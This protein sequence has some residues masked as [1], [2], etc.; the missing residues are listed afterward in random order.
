MP[1]RARNVLLFAACTALT[2][3]AVASYYG[4]STS[5]VASDDGWRN[6]VSWRL[7]LLAR[8]A[9]GQVPDLS[10]PELWEMANTRGGF[11][12]E[13]FVRN[14]VSLDGSLLSPHTTDEDVA[15]GSRVFA[16]HCAECHGRPGPGRK[17]PALDQPGYSRGDSDLAIYK[18]LRNGIPA[19]GMA[20]PAI[21][22]LERWQ[23][24]AYLRDL[25]T[26][27]TRRRQGSTPHVNVAARQLEMTAGTADEWPTHSGSVDGQRYSTLAEVTP[28][29]VSQLRLLWSRQFSGAGIESTPLVAD[30]MMYITLPPSTVMALDVDSGVIVWTYS[31]SLPSDLSLC[32][33]QV[34]RGAAILGDSLFLGTLDGHLV[35]LNANTGELLW[36]TMVA[37]P[38][39]GYTITGAPLVSGRSVVIGTAGAE[40]GIRGILDAYDPATGERQWRF[41]TIPGPDETGHETWENEAWRTGGGST[42]VTGSYDPSLNLVYWGVGNPAP[43]FAGHVRPGDNLFT[44]SVVALHADSGRLAWHFQFTPHDEHD[45]DSAQTPILANVTIDGRARRVICWPNRNG[46]YYVLDRVTGGFVAGVPFIDLNWARGLDSGGRPV[47]VE[48]G[49]P[50]AQGRLTKPGRNGAANWQNSAF[51]PDRGLVF[52]PATEGETVYTNTPAPRRGASGRYL[53]SAAMATT[54]THVVRA[55]DATTGM[56]RWEYFPRYPEDVGYSGLLAT[57]GGL[58]FGATGGF[59][60]ALESA[61]GTER[62]TVPLGGETEAPPI[63]FT[64]HGR[65]ALAVV[66][67]RTVFVFGL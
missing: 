37:D 3:T 48:N 58:V 39:D 34:N 7:R 19:A 1:R 20:A 51:D 64:R 5:F 27:R 12:L 52:V 59:L 61:T 4:Y 41:N 44:N 24:V 43:P 8:K 35:A 38:R 47:L 2:L 36:E 13:N 31:R 14:G 55:L 63:S 15:L 65:Q 49:G 30:G 46:F 22:A 53:G 6:S 66:A 54:A 60:F 40:Y 17:A 62:W 10:W 23:V 32:C 26:A 42:W 56:K 16:E 45:W 50:S 9:G 33:G 29:N 28:A 21:T 25:Q 57:R 67:G 11:G 18:V